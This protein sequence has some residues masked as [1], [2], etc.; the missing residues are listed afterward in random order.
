MMYPV[1]CENGHNLIK[2]D[3]H[4]KN[5]IFSAKYC[6]FCKNEKLIKLIKEKGGEL[7][8]I[9]D[10]LL[11]KYSVIIV[12]CNNNHEFKTSTKVLSM[13]HWCNQCSLFKLEKICK[14]YFE[15]IFGVLFIKIRPDFLK[16]LNGKNLELD[17]FNENLKIAFEHQGSQ[18]YKISKTFKMDQAALDD[19]QKKDK[20]KI[21]LCKENNI[22][23]FIIPELTTMTKIENLKQ[24]IFD[25][26]VNF[27]IEKLGNFN[28][29]IDLSSINDS[30]IIEFCNIAKAHGGECISKF[31]VDAHSKLNFI[32]AEGHSFSA[33]ACE[34]KNKKTWCMTCGGCEKLTIEDM[35]LLAKSKGGKCLSDVYENS[36][37]NL[38]WECSEGH[39]WLAIPS[40]IRRGTWCAKCN[41]NKKLTI[42]EMQE[43]AQN[44]NGKCLSVKYEKALGLLTWECIN[45]HKFEES[46]HNIIAR[47]KRKS[48]WCKYCADDECKAK[49]CKN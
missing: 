6:D 36:L 7:I 44:N 25:Q 14:L 9:S 22:N 20:L 17:G 46:Y 31:Y 23:L 4:Q 29:D 42:K 10:G 27:N 38:Y 19:I 3:R 15:Q 48:N 47:I 37:K 13:G 35:H 2:Y 12:K 21:K 40:N 11:T 45:N 24:F 41:G 16:Q 34:I 26:A 18:H 49:R 43:L 39:R 1:K 33:E 28:V 5:I 32:C 8:S 30:P